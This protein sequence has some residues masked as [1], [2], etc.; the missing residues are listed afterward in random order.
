M[1]DTRDFFIMLILLILIAP[2]YVFYSY[3]RCHS[4]YEDSGQVS[5]GIIK[6]C[7]IKNDITNNKWTPVENYR[8]E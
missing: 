2:I 6:G 5:Y 1:D 4:K 3:H 7:T 8:V